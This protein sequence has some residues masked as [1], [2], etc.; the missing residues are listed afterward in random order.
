MFAG[1]ENIIMSKIS[2]YSSKYFRNNTIPFSSERKTISYYQ[3]IHRHDYFEIEYILSGSGKYIINGVSYEIEPNTLFFSTPSDFQEII[4]ST[5]TDLLN[6]QF[7]PEMVDKEIYLNLTNPVVLS[8]SKKSYENF[9]HPLCTYSPNN[10]KYNELFVRHILNAALFLISSS[11]KRIVGQKQYEINEYFHKILVYINKNF[12]EQITL[13]E[14]AKQMNLT[15]E[16]ISRLFKKNSGQTI[17][18]YITNMRLNYAL[19]LVNNT[20]IPINEIA[21]SSGYN[22]NPHFIRTFKEKF[23]ISPNKMRKQNTGNTTPQQ[24]HPQTERCGPGMS[25]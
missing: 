21:I 24:N 22:S 17:S 5:H 7:T 19:K 1:K 14:L 25:L 23:G 2:K 10:G 8:D 18:D 11:Q 4:F 6:I 13:T 9:F 20:K 16:Y 12:Q 3:A 15:P